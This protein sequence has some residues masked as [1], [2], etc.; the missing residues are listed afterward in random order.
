MWVGISPY[1]PD[2]NH[3]V[4]SISLSLSLNLSLRLRHGDYCG[5]V[6]GERCGERGG[7]K[8]HGMIG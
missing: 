3:T 4:F 2:L 5:C 8:V 7:G 6:L 1:L